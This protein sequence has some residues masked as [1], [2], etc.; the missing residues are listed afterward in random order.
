MKDKVNEYNYYY[1]D[2]L[3]WPI[4]QIMAR[5]IGIDAAAALDN[6]AGNLMKNISVY[7]DARLILMYNLW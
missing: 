4:I 6:K 3:G 1:L 7:I 2:R 5:N